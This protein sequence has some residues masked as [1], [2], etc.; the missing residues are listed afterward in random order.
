MSGFRQHLMLRTA[1]G[2]VHGLAFCLALSACLFGNSGAV[3]A[4][5]ST[6]QPQ[7]GTGAP[8]TPPLDPPGER[9]LASGAG[10]L[11]IGQWLLSPTLDLY[12][13]YNSNIQSSPTLDLKGSGFHYRPALQAELDTGI[14]DTKLYGNFDSTLY[15][16]QNELNTFNRQAGMYETYAPL[17]DLIFNTHIDYTHNTNANV[18]ITSIPV[19]VTSPATPAPEGAAG[20]VATQ[21]TMVN[22]ND[23][24]TATASVY[25]EFNRAFLNLGSTI[26]LTQYEMSSSSTSP[27]YYKEVYNGQG[28]FWFS[29]ILYAF[30]GAIDTNTIPAVGQISNSYLARS[31]IGSAQIGLFQGSVYY[32]QQGTAVDQGGGT[33]GG[34]IYGGTLSY[35]PTSV[36]HMSLSVDRLR[37][38]SDIT[39]TTPG[40]G[41]LPGLALSASNV[42]SASSTQITTIA[43]KSDYMFS[44]Q[45]SAH[46]VVSDAR[47]A[48]IDMPRVDNSW[49]A[50]AG[51]RHQLR[52]NLSLTLDYNYTRYI[53]E[54]P[55]TSFNR[56]L[57]TAGAHYKF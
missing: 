12:T 8:G 49:L 57:V 39:G 15:P 6:G 47:I 51:I 19:P 31:G 11:S 48:F 45:T 17:R 29:P 50:S 7:V 43:Y 2:R 35:F 28:G 14:Y 13:L 38:R 42:T 54:Q 52:D 34:D 3:H 24:Y 37:N 32:G 56:S 30:A 9:A 26:A 10:M 41:G 5:A 23:V 25:K 1:S 46:V 16:T 22:P 44:E 36:W 53:S 4:Q 40:A 21:Q 55:L 27:N 33:A 20:V 18:V